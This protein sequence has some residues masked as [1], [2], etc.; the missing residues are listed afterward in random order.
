MMEYLIPTVRSKSV[1]IL[2]AMLDLSCF[3]MI[4]ALGGAP[5]RQWLQLPLEGKSQYTS[6]ARGR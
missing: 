2:P 1:V 5:T 6:K 3:A 4:A